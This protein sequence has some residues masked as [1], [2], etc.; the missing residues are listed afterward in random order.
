VISK[1]KEEIMRRVKMA[2]FGKDHWSLLAYVET[3]CVESSKKGVGE[4]SKDRMRCNPK[5]HPL[6]AV[7]EVRG[8]HWIDDYSSRLAGY[9]P[10]TGGTDKS[11]MV[12]GHDDWDC[13]DDL[14]AAK[15]I[16]VLSEANGFVILSD[17]G[18]E[19]A[20]RIRA[21]KTKGGSFSNFS[22]AETV[23]S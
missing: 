15:L 13:L 10:E 17:L 14:E 21:H 3:L 1:K 7:N 6:H 12:R 18:R 4:I 2:E 5:H 16:E 8:V 20:G 9:Y 19:M 23:S 22:P 11:K